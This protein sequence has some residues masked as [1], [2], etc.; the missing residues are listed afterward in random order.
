MV[1]ERAREADALWLPEENHAWTCTL[2]SVLWQE[3][4]TLA[5][6]VPCESHFKHRASA[7]CGFSAPECWLAGTD[8]HE[9]CAV[10]LMLPDTG[11]GH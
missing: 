8:S 3:R 6:Q 1:L 2:T 4:Q 10:A 11:Q 5:T 7:G 9:R